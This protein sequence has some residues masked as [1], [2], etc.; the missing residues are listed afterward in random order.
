MT[1][2]E[3][4]HL[5]CH[6]TTILI[7]NPGCGKTTYLIA[8]LEKRVK[9]GIPLH[10]IGFWSFSN[11]AV[12][13]ASQRARMALTPPEQSQKPL[14]SLNALSEK[15]STENS[16][17]Q[18]DLPYFRTLHSMAFQ[19]LNLSQDNLMTD[20]NLEEFGNLH[21]Y[22]FNQ[23]VRAN[24]HQSRLTEFDKALQAIN[25]ARLLDVNI[26]DY[27]IKNNK[28][29]PV[30]PIE[31][32]A[33]EY[34]NY[35]LVK[36]VFDYTDM[37][38]LAKTADIEFPHLKIAYIDEAQDLAT[39][40]WVLA[41]RQAEFCD[42]IIIAGDDKQSINKFSGAD[43]DT[44]LHLPG[45]V[46]S[47]EQSYRVPNKIWSLANRIVDRHMV[48]YRKEGANWKPRDEEGTLLPID[49]PPY[50]NILNGESWLI[51]ARANYQLEP[52]AK[53]LI[54]GCRE[55]VPFTINGSAPVEIGI[56]ESIIY[57]NECHKKGLNPAEDLLV[58]KNNDSAAAIRKKSAKIAMLKRYMTPANCGVS[59]QPLEITEQFKRACGKDWRLALDKLPIGT[60]NYVQ[61]LLPE[62]MEKGSAL[63][64]DSNIKLMSIHSAK[65]READNVMLLLDAPRAVSETIQG[66][67]KFEDDTEAK[68]V[69]VAVTRARKRLY[70]WKY[71]KRNVGLD[72]FFK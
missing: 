62:Y 41:D 70:T 60:L 26:K 28:G 1:Y 54:N 15:S 64:R 39:L 21:N 2:Y 68:V 31:R 3:M 30:A 49:C 13:E 23:S 58:F 7:G 11:A 38:V 45:K 32:M 67:N 47:L 9:Q 55:A 35:K 40:L 24:G 29:L 61:K 48:N 72:Y 51:L 44:F 46:Q 36:G 25:T 50:R 65:G 34:E 4:K 71:N 56:F 69:Y 57:L 27:L 14:V 5:N 19:L 59:E 20:S 63:F 18:L 42:E 52:I 10:Q 8:D 6:N 17:E 33:E 53:D 43:V 12:D 66:Y 16:Q 22:K 37:L